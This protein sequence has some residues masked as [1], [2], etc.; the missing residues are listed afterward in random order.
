[1]H[2]DVRQMF[3]GARTPTIDMDDTGFSRGRDNDFEVGRT[4]LVYAHQREGAPGLISRLGLC[5]PTKLLEKAG[6]E[7]ASV[8]E[9]A[10]SQKA[11]VIGTVFD[12]DHDVAIP[13]AG[14]DLV[15]TCGSH[16]YRTRSDKTGQFH[17][18]GVAAEDTTCTLRPRIG[19]D[20]YLYDGGTDHLPDEVRLGKSPTCADTW[21]TIKSNGRIRGRVV[22][23]SGVPVPDLAVDVWSAPRMLDWTQWPSD[24]P[25][26]NQDGEFEARHLPPGS[27][28]LGVNSRTDIRRRFEFGT[29]AYFAGGASAA[30][31][32]VVS[33]GAG[34]RVDLSSRFALPVDVNVARVRG[35][36]TTES[37]QPASG[38]VV[39]I[40]TGFQREDG[41]LLIGQ[42]FTDVDGRFSVT[43][44]VG[45]SGW[46]E[47]LWP[48]SSASWFEPR[49]SAKVDFRVGS[50]DLHVALR[51]IERQ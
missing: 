7:L 4:Y 17:F 36:A 29:A 49:E 21:L 34:Q 19:E 41:A 47:I 3:R 48:G 50:T 27:Y 15:L 45:A 24:T 37:G 14:A 40:W 9:L 43:L 32:T 44:P 13:L 35:T 25:R 39:R 5:S 33:V 12:G 20:R 16:V 18:F 23:A 1:V 11:T 8:R 38:A 22:D 42:I 28:V 2:F 46:L 30:D 31:A 10:A 51:P 26:T 6:P